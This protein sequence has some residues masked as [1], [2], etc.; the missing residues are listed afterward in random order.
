VTTPDIVSDLRELILR[1][2]PDETKVK[3]ILTCGED[4][5]LDALM[6]F[7]SVVV[8]GVIVAVEDR[9][10]VSVTRDAFE[11]AL[12]GGVTLRKIAEMVHS[13]KSNL[14]NNEN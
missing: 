7:S 11:G 8:L 3:L 6:P 1:S 13:L 2:A 12:K 9:Y 4:E 5:R 10:G 14:A